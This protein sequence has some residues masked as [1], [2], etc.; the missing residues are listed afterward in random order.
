MKKSILAFALA[1]FAVAGFAQEKTAPRTE[2]TV[3]LSSTS[4]SAKPGETQDVTITLS[5]SKSYAKSKATLGVSTALP[6][7]VTIS[8][9]PAEGVI[10]SSVAHIAVASDVKPGSYLII[11]NSSIQNKSKGATLRLVVGA[12]EVASTH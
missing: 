10:E 7:G 12:D 6:A 1:T 9:E 11:L 5:R 2:Y 8:F 3:D 4:V